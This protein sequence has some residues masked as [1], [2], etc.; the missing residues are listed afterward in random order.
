[1]EDIMYNSEIL[2][3]K[4]E[5]TLSPKKKREL[6]TCFT[7]NIVLAY[8]LTGNYYKTYKMVTGEIISKEFYF[9]RNYCNPIFLQRCYNKYGDKMVGNPLKYYTKFLIG[10]DARISLSSWVIT[11]YCLGYVNNNFQVRMHQRGLGIVDYL[12]R[13]YIPI[14][15]NAYIQINQFIFNK[16]INSNNYDHLKE[17][18]IAFIN[19][20]KGN[21]LLIKI[22]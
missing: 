15:D 18:T 11:R 10:N 2:R 1:M 4:V 22:K 5:A 20:L 7:S 9:A 21:N 3:M 8:C 12:F 19:E 17:E 13:K 6:S 14:H 16:V